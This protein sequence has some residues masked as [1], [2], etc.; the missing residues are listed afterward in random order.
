MVWFVNN[1]PG[2]GAR[3][4][5]AAQ[6]LAG[7][8]DDNTPE[9]RSQA[10]QAL[11]AW[12]TKECLP[13]L[14]AHAQR[15]QKNPSDGPALIDVLAQFPDDSAAEAIGLLL[16]NAQTR[17]KAV[18]ALL[19]PQFGPAATKV[20]LPYINHP[21][22]GVQ[23]AARELCRRLERPRRRRQLD[24]TLADAAD[25][26]I[27]RSRAA[28]QH[29]AALRPDDASRAKVSAALNA[30]LLDPHP[31]IRADALNAVKVWAT[32]ANTAALAED[33]WETSEVPE[34]ENDACVVIDLLGSL[35]DPKAAPDLAQ[36]L[37]PAPRRG[38]AMQGL[39]LHRPRGGRR[40]PSG[41][42]GGG[43]GGAASRPAA[44]SP[45]SA[46]P[47]VCSPYK[48]PS[49][50]PRAVPPGDAVIFE[51]QAAMQKIGARK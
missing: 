23:K 38:P 47:G 33:S 3:K 36:V 9:I 22:A 1:T 32:Q 19:Q 11:K 26:R 4:D 16:P 20:V 31:E 42:S 10:L 25:A 34:W 50:R 2:E 28:L 40:G 41:P 17:D 24:Q 37:N 46:L 21:D 15:E 7:L 49:A 43:P 8:L 29:L 13:Q 5:D 39:G 12:A 18:Q 45:T 51:A 44:S 48:T 6:A 14:L 27:P 30:S 35:K